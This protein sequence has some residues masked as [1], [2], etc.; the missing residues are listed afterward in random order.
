MADM[1]KQ[2]KVHYRGFLDDGREFDNSR[3]YGAPLEISPSEDEMLPG[4][5]EALAEMEVG[6]IWRVRIP[7][8]EAYGEYDDSLIESVPF[9]SFP[10]AD[11]LPVGEYISIPFGDEPITVKVV[12][13]EDGLI[14]FDH[15]HELAG[16][17]LNF[18]IQL[19][20]VSGK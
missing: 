14:F 15:N 9:D 6:D 4:F 1:S 18:E 11:K 12:K 16:E 8:E 2:L 3:R 19:V 7:A 5:A 17:A 13:I 20:S 10:N